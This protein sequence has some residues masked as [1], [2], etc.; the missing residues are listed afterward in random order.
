ME[1]A[2]NMNLPLAWEKFLYKHSK[3]SK[4]HALL[5]EIEG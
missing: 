2:N 5:Q 1:C 3:K 4:Q